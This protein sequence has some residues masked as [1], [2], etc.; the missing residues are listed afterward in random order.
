MF[1]EKKN[2][3]EKKENNKI[4]S[5]LKKSLCCFL[6]LSATGC[7]SVCSEGK[8]RGTLCLTFDDRTFESWV[9]AIPLFA[10]YN[11]HATFFIYGKID[12]QA[13]EAM[14]KLQ[15]AGHTVGLHALTHAK[16]VEYSE[17]YSAD[18]YVKNEIMP[19]M[20][21]CR[22]NNINIRAFAYPYSQRN[23]A[24]DAALFKQFD[25]LRSNYSAVVPKGTELADADG[26]FN[27]KINKKHLFHGFP[28]SGNF[29]AVA[30]K[31]AMDRAAKED[32]VIVFYAHDIT[33][34]IP[35]S[36]HIAKFQLE[37]LLQYAASLGMA[38]KGMNEF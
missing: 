6:A 9:N 36:H 10:K 15:D 31:K 35:P 38:I 29:D 21:I 7:A 37:D 22:Q 16:A 2:C 23:A 34:Q 5:V 20:E 11:A 4:V 25:F 24:T 3:S 13:L 8:K 28:S 26:F 18:D 30:I 14:K 19:Q 27:R 17:K 32:A 1:E 12:G 33:E